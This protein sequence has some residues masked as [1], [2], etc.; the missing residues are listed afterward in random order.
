MAFNNYSMDDLA[1]Q[2]VIN[3]HKSLMDSLN[4]LECYGCNVKSQINENLIEI[5]STLS[6]MKGLLI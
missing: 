2:Y 5:E 6:K 1:I 3:A 4:I